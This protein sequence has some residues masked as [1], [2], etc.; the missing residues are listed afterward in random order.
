MPLP[1]QYGE[2]SVTQFRRSA[3][4]TVL[5]LELRHWV[6]RGHS[7]GFPVSPADEPSLPAV[8]VLLLTAGVLRLRHH[9]GTSLP[10][11]VL[12]VM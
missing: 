7:Y 3:V 9:A 4:F 8:K 10:E 11:G 5:P 12:V 1:E 6:D 2:G